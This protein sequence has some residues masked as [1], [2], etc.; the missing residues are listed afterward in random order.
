MLQA[1]LGVVTNSIQSMFFQ[2]SQAVER[3]YAGEREQDTYLCG[4]QT[5]M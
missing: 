2:T 4:D 3:N 1:F 5:K